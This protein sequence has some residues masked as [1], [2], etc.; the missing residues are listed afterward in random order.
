MKN[1][2]R[3]NI[4]LTVEDRKNFVDLFV[5][6]IAVDRRVNTRPRNKPKAKKNTK[7]KAK[8]KERGS[9]SR[10]LFFMSNCTT[11]EALKLYSLL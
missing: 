10:A 7:A 11:F 9:Q 3:V 8:R 6:L 5:I 2:P 1:P 4:L